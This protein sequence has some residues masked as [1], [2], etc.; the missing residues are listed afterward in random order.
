MKLAELL[1]LPSGRRAM[2]RSIYIHIPF[3]SSKCGYCDFH[4][5]PL[6]S[7]SS[8]LR[9]AYIDRI[10]S[11]LAECVEAYEAPFETLYI[12]GGTPTALEDNLFERLLRGVDELAGRGVLEWTL[13]AN[14]ESLSPRKAGIAAASGVTRL[15]LGIQSMDDGELKVLGRKARSEDNKRAIKLALASGLAVSADLISS[16]PAEAAPGGGAGPGKRRALAESLAFL[17]DEGVGHISLY[18][19]VVEKGTPLSGR[20]VRGELLPTDADEA[21]EERKE[22]E[23][24]L[25]ERGYARYEVSN[26]APPGAQ[27]L[28]NSVYWCMRSYLGIGSGA[29]STLVSEGPVFDP[30]DLATASLRMEE[31]RD[32]GAWLA[33][34]D[35][36][37]SISRLSRKDSAFETIMMGLRTASGLDTERFAARFGGDP[38]SILARTLGIWKGEFGTRSG[39]R[40]AVNDAGLDLLNPILVDAL[41]DV[42]AF[43]GE[44][45]G[46]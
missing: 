29:V 9:S 10:L 42:E 2:P 16:I 41:I 25:V 5:L 14:P 37:L 21:Y 40:L 7:I 19:L 3:C 34:P 11:R 1:T 28:H 20:L 36:C 8:A 13:E 27:S 31:G 45:D 38:E 12:G 6:G 26:F 15:S 46:T 17:L 32:L 43:F 24:R 18:D 22:A 33:E 44:N 4:S 23:R 30:A 35:A 39:G